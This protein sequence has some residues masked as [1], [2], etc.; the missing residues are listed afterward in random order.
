MA[1][2]QTKGRPPRDKTSYRNEI[3]R[4]KRDAAER[5][6]MVDELIETITYQ[7]KKL[8]AYSFPTIKQRIKYLIKGEI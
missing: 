2:Q 4:M 7:A 1:K 3:Q 6:V 8:H 5:Q